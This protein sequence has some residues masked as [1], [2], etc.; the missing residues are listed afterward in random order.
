[1][2]A[3]YNIFPWDVC[4]RKVFTFRYKTGYKKYNFNKKTI[5]DK[6]NEA[7]FY[8]AMEIKLELV[9]PWGDVDLSLEEKHYFY[10]FSKNR[11]TFDSDFSVRLSKQI[12]VYSKMQA[13]VIHDQLYLPKGDASLEDLL[14]KR[15]KLA[16]TYEVSGEI[17]LRFTF[18]SIYNNVVNE[19]L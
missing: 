17:G 12:S 10:D 2:A 16:T 11:M 4:N 14:L 9:Q 7:H 15:R 19:R 5:Y 3:E 1:M 6:L 13:E 8:E 18:G